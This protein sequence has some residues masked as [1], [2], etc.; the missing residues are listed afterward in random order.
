MIVDGVASV[1][2][3]G[4]IVPLV[5]GEVIDINVGAAHRVENFGKEKPT[6][7]EIQRGSYFG[8]DNFERLEEDFGR[9][10]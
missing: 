9:A 2:L 1:T 8:E 5:A 6:F 3:D 7:I 10:Y 4:K